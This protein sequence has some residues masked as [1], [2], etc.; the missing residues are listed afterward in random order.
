MAS[1]E[2]Q[3]LESAL[4]LAS[5][6]ATAAV[7]FTRSST[8]SFKERKLEESQLEAVWETLIDFAART[9]H[10]H[11]APLAETVSEIQKLNLS[12]EENGRKYDIWGEKLDIWTDMPLLGP[13]LRDAWNKGLFYI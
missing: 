5:P 8:M 10:E 1:R 7:A 13:A 11:Q 9:P 3:A 2:Y 12:A 4:S 6:P